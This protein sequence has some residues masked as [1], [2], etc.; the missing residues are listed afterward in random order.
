MT[1]DFEQ[2]IIPDSLLLALF[3]YLIMICLYW[4]DLAV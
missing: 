1:A 2:A 4:G 3:A